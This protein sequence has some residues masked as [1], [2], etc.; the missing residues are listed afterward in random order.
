MSSDPLRSAWNAARRWGSRLSHHD[1]STRSRSAWDRLLKRLNPP[2]PRAVSGPVSQSDISWATCLRSASRG[3]NARP[4]RTCSTT[5]SSE[6]AGSPSTPGA[7]VSQMAARALR[8]LGLS[9]TERPYPLD[10]R[11]ANGLHAGRPRQDSNLEASRDGERRVA[12]SRSCPRWTPPAGFEPGGEPGRRA[13]GRRFAILPALDAPGRIRTCDPLLRRQPL[14]SPEL[15][16]HLAPA[17]ALG[18][19]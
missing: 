3:F 16:G 5:P 11:V 17:Y 9:S 8:C 1:R 6:A 2:P 15:R 7:N 18:Q 13:T 4:S 12:G 14:Q 19:P 10:V